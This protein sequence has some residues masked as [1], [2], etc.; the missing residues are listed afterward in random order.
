MP[1]LAA[2]APGFP[3]FLFSGANRPS[4][5]RDQ[6]Q[7]AFRDLDQSSASL[8]SSS[9]WL[10]GRH[11]IKFGGIYSRNYAKDGY[12]TGANESKGA[13]AFS[14]FATGN[15]FADL[16]L[17]LP[18]QVREQR[19][20]RGDQPMDT[21]SN[22]WAVFAQDDLKLTPRLTLFLGLRYEVIGVFVDKNDIYAN[23]VPTDGGHHVVPNTAIAALLPPGAVRL[24]RT[25][26]S[27]QF[28]VGRGLIKTDRNNISPRVGF[29]QR[30]D[31][32]NKTVLRGG[33][34]IFHPTGAAQGARDI[35]SRNPFRYT[36]TIHPAAAA[37]GLL[38][39]DAE[40]VARLRQSGPAA[41]SGAAGHLSVQP[42][43]RARAARRPWRP[44][45][46]PRIDDEEAAGAPRLQHGAGERRAARQRG[47]GSRRQGAT[48]VPDLRH[49]H[50]HHR[51]HAAK[52]SSTR[53]SWS[54]SAASRAGFAVNAAYTLAGSDSNAPDSGNSTIG[55]VQYDPYDIEKDRGPDPNVVKHRV[56]MNSTWEIP[57]GRERP[58]RRRSCRGGLTRSSAG[59]RCP[60]SFRRAADRT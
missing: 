12:S 14:G 22:D 7:N 43:A 45:Q 37:A 49:V 48:A 25:L 39:R 58:I 17:G 54:C 36:I 46:L 26:T 6:R 60:R 3:S 34:G 18:N 32:S 50:G 53:C 8:S 24:G 1:P 28:D 4:D 15:A 42:H 59:G 10:K 47:H 13:Y 16:L 27:D 52:D 55:V 35:M 51:E 5:I 40:R 21:F 11:S 30:L 38:V 31:N 20:T 33:F 44:R 41:G 57:V 29:A 9:T 56:V 23:F 2:E 19:N